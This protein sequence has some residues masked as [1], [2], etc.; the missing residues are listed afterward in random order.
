MSQCSVMPC[1]LMLFY[2]LKPF[3]I[4]PKIRFLR[5]LVS[6]CVFVFVLADNKLLTLDFVVQCKVNNDFTIIFCSS[7][8]NEIIFIMEIAYDRIIG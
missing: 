1:G 8:R 2:L 7:V 3:T 6:N 5:A 4:Q